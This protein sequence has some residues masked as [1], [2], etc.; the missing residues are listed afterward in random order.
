MSNRVFIGVGHGGSDPGSV[1]YVVEKDVALV[2]SLAT[3]DELEKFGVIVGISR[4]QD[5]DD[6]LIEEIDECTA[7]AADLAVEIHFNAGGGDG[8]ECFVQTNG[9]ESQSRALARCIEVQVVAMGQYSRGLKTKQGSQGDYF[10]WLR[11]NKCPA[12]LLEGF[13]V[14]TSDAFDFDSVEEQKALGRAYA[15]GILDYLDINYSADAYTSEIRG[16]YTVTANGGL[17]LRSGASTEDSIRETMP[18]GSY[19]TCYGYYNGDWYYVESQAGNTGYCYKEYLERVLP[20]V[21]VS[22]TAYYFDA[23]KWALDH[24]ITSG[25]SEDTFSP[26]ANCTRAEAVTMLWALY[27]RPEPAEV[28]PFDDVAPT[29][30]FAKAAQWARSEGITVG[31]GDGKF[32]PDDVCTRGQIV[33]MLWRAAGSPEV[34]GEMPFV[35]VKDDD[36]FA[37]A[38]KWAKANGIT[39]GVDATHFAPDRPC[40]RAEMVSFLYKA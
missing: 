11:L 12:I 23:V 9:Y 5:E 4:T 10:G 1:G 3:K 35:D 20:F 18:K 16:V 14:D 8:W 25:T 17:N 32:G 6:D 22:P 30:Y 31:I 37:M 28:E 38:V 7:F 13:F 19:A 36:Y 21:D 24:G 26:E 15:Y 40:T 33:T 29:D 39:A 2:V 34:E 27:G